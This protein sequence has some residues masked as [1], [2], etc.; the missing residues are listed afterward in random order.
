MG[1]EKPKNEGQR[2]GRMRGKEA[3]GKESMSQKK[4]WELRRRR[5]TMPKCRWNGIAWEWNGL[6]LG[7][8]KR[9]KCQ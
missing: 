7:E 2:M 6:G 1:T 5:R 3:V 9:R 8:R 4:G